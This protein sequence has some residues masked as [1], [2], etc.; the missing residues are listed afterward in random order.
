MRGKHQLVA[1]AILGLAAIPYGSAVAS[2]AQLQRSVDGSLSRALEAQAT[3]EGGDP[4]AV[5]AAYDAARDFQESVRASQPVSPSCVRL[6]RV[7]TSL[8]AALVRVQ[9]G[10]DRPSPTMRATA[11]S[12]VRSLRGKVS[13][14]R[15][16]CAG[17]GKSSAVPVVPMRPASGQAFFGSMASRGPVGSVRARILVGKR[18]WKDLPLRGRSLD[19]KATGPYRKYDFTIKF[20][21]GSGKTV[22]RAEAKDTWLL[23]ATGKV[24]QPAAR[25]DRAL[26][27]RLQSIARRSPGTVAIWAQDLTRG[28]YA[29]T[30]AGARFPA[31]STVKL[32]VL[33]GAMKRV[34]P[35]P[36]TSPLFY[37]LK[38]IANW[39]SNLAANRIV[40]RLGSGCSSARDQ[41]ANEGLRMLGAVSSTYTGCYIV[42]TELQPQMPPAPATSSPPLNT[43][44]YTTAQ[45]LGRMMFALQAAAVPTPSARIRTGLSSKQARQIIGLLL[46]SQRA[47]G[48]RSLVAAGTPR[49]TPI[50][51]KNGWLRSTRL[52]ASIAYLPTGPVILTL[53]AYSPS[54]FPLATA[55]RLGADAMRANN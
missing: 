44:R 8:S 26:A 37:D 1:G 11:R 16:R 46:S 20:L 34:G 48:N 51:Q 45:D 19:Y 25:K 18:L 47:G 54:G 30:N 42:G 22:G 4:S 39:S 10:F 55:Q 15:G 17:D 41:L 13:S 14:A 24:A 28:T 36:E 32:G 38:A 40:K 23:P 3:A 7:A 27:S 6:F 9:E 2:D 35:R 49:G 33:A 29:G 31:A 53:A 43:Q 21:D 12:E 50:A 5:Q 52:S